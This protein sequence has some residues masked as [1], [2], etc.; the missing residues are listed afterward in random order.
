MK[1]RVIYVLTHDSIGV[2]EDG[3]THQPTEI[4]AGLR[5]MPNLKVYRPA[6]AVETLECWELALSDK[7]SP[8]ALILT[9]QNVPAVR[10]VNTDE[11][12]S[13]RGAYILCEAECDR[14]VTIFA[15][16]SEV[17]IAVRA[18]EILKNEGIHAAVVSMPCW[19]LF[20][21][22]EEKYREFIL[23][24]DSVSI[25]VEASISPTWD[26]Y[27]GSK[28]AFIGLK[29]FGLSAPGNILYEYFGITAEKVAEAAREKLKE[30]KE[31][32]A[33][34]SKMLYRERR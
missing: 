28:G 32:L 5:I 24:H 20:D 33:V 27:I 9:R 17:H 30:K 14:D 34:L 13:A 6:D 29:D 1:Q 2:G 21:L 23:G 7:H 31:N 15:T 18:R 8:S 11:N 10:I 16:G 19:E 22:Q 4:L 25:A 26:K 12:L 3:P